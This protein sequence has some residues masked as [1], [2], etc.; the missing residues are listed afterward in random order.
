[1]NSL[2]NIPSVD[3]SPLLESISTS[4]Q[5]VS[6]QTCFSHPSLVVY[7][8]PPTAPIKLKLGLQIGGR[9]LITNHL[10]QS[11]YCF[12]VYNFTSFWDQRESIRPGPIIMLGQLEIG[13]SSQIIFIS[14][15]FSC[16]CKEAFALP[17]TCL[18]KLCKNAEPNWHV[19]IFLHPILILRVTWYVCKNF[20]PSYLWL[21]T[22]N[23]I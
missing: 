1:M 18:T 11:V 10:D 20:G 9:L 12:T 6:L 15:S 22:K 2:R 17:F 13:N 14:L 8:F 7:F 19:L 3:G 5:Y 16:R 21:H 4:D 23:Q